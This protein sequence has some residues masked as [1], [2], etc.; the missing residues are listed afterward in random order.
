MTLTKEHEG[1]WDSLKAVKAG[2]KTS[3]KAS[4]SQSAV[5]SPDTSTRTVASPELL[6]PQTDDSLPEMTLEKAVLTAVT[7]GTVGKDTTD[8]QTEASSE[9]EQQHSGIQLLDDDAADTATA[10][11]VSA[12]T[13][14]AK[15]VETKAALVTES[16]ATPA[17]PD[18]SSLSAGQQKR[19]MGRVSAPAVLM[20]SLVFELD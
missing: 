17:L 11:S 2:S 12:P 9:A 6:E 20:S 5:Q 4:P 16:F 15:P 1:L 13:S 14:E 10:D 19:G 7:A 3:P 18:M 8:L